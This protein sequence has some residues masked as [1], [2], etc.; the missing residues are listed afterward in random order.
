MH[1]FPDTGPFE[2]RMQETELAYVME[3]WN[4]A[5]AVAENYVGLPY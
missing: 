1:R 2:Q 3:S 5:A 4:A